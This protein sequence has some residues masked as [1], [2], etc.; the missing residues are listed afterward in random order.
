MTKKRWLIPVLVMLVIIGAAGAAFFLS[1][2]EGDMIYASVNIQPQEQESAE[3]LAPESTFAITLDYSVSQEQLRAMLSIEPDMGEYMIEGSG[4]KWT[5]RPM[6]PL[7]ENT[8]YTVR[9]INPDTGAAVQSF[10]FQTRS[11]LLVNTV[12]PGDGETFVPLE[13]GIE[14]TLNAQNV[15]LQNHMEIKPAVAGSFETN[16]YTVVFKPA[17]PLTANSIYRVTLKAGLTAPGGMALKEDYTFSFETAQAEDAQRDYER[18]RLDSPY[19]ET[20]LPGDPLTVKLQSGGEV[21]GLPFN[22][23]IHRYGDISGYMKE[24]REYNA[25]YRERYGEKTDYVANTTGLEEVASYTGELFS[26]DSGWGELYAILP[27]DLGEGW[28]VVTISGEDA[29]GSDQFVQKLVQVCNLSVYSQSADG[30]TLFWLN[31]PATGGPVAKA[32][33]QLEDVDGEG[34]FPAVTMADGTARVMTGESEAVYVTVLRDGKSVYFAQAPLSQAVETPPL[35][36]QYYTALYT[37]REAYQP[38][39]TIHFWGVV[40]PRTG[41]SALPQN[42]WVSLSTSWP[43]AE[44]Y[45]VKAAVNQADGTF[46]GAIAVTGIAKN[47]YELSVNDGEQGVYTSKGLS[48]EKYTKPPYEIGVTLDK[49][50]YYFD[51]AVGVSITARYFDGTPVSGETLMLS[52]SY[53]EEQSVTLDAS[54][55]AGCTVRLKAPNDEN[56]PMGWSPRSLWIEARNISAQDVYVSGS[57]NATVL[58]SRIALKLEGDSLERLTIRTAQLDD[59]KLNGGN[60]ISPLE[61]YD[62]EY[63]RLAGAPVDVPVTVLIHSVTRRQVETGSYYD[64]VNKRTVTEYETE[65][66]EAVAETIETKT[67]G[68]VVTLEGLAYKNTDDTT[69]WAEARVDGGA[70]G[71]V[72]ETNQFGARPYKYRGDTPIYTFFNPDDGAAAAPVDVGDTVT[73]RLYRNGVKTENTGRVLYSILQRRSLKNGV[74]DGETQTLT[75]EE[76]FLPNIVIAGAYFDGRHIYAVEE[77]A[78]HYDYTD[79]GLTVTAETDKESYRPGET[80]TVTLKLTDA[81]GN[82]V[83]G[84]VCVGVADEAAFDVAEQHAELLYQLYSAVYY[85]RLRR[86]LSY[87]EYD[88][89]ADEKTSANAEGGATPMMADTGGGAGGV[90]LREDFADTALFKTAK[91]DEN[92]QAS[93]TFELP[94]NVTSW[95]ITALAVTDDLK[96][97]DTA[98]LAAAT[99][100]FYLTPLYTDTYLEGDDVVIAAGAVGTGANPGDAVSYTVTIADAAGKELDKQTAE[101]TIGVRVPFSFGKLEAGAYTL[102]MESVCGE[103]SDAVRYPFS[104]VKQALTTP[105][106]ENMPLKDTVN[107]DSVRYPVKLMVYDQRMQPYMEGLQ[108]LSMQAGERTEII[109]AAYRAQLAYNELL[110]EAEREPVR[111]DVRLDDIQIGDGG[112]R[113]L[114]VSESSAAVTAK[115]LVAAPELINK[116][117]ARDYLKGVL[118]NP[119]AAQDDRVM[120]Y[121]GLAAAK[122]PILLDLLRIISE[123]GASMTDAQRLYLGTGLALLGDFTSADLVYHSLGGRLVKDGDMLYAEGADGTLDA[124]IQTSAAALMLASVTSNPDADALM[125]Y[126]NNLD[127][128]RAKSYSTLANLE[129][130][131]YINSFTPPQKGAESFSY[132][133]TQGEMQKRTLENGGIEPLSMSYEALKAANFQANGN[134]YACA[135]YTGYADAAQIPDDERVQ[136]TKTYTPV[137]GDGIGVS[138]RVRVDLTVRFSDSAPDGCYIVSDYIPSGMRYMETSGVLGIN[139]YF[140]WMWGG[141]DNE[142]QAVSGRI[143]RNIAVWREAQAALT[144]QQSGERAA[145]LA[146]SV[147]PLPDSAAAEERGTPSAGGAQVQK[148]TDVYTLTYYVSAALP[149]EFVSESAYVTPY[150]EGTAAKSERGMVTVEAQG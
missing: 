143:Y 5:L 95:R 85:P 74:F 96:A 148:D 116:G 92:G 137:A 145:P 10:A 79:K 109:A 122:E 104:V 9:V 108:Y 32:A 17:E 94:D 23:K 72:C 64:Y 127:R 117:A 118:Q 35:S 3:P 30:D 33:L 120:A 84:S 128:D 58:P 147:A 102:T 56:D 98:R 26:K 41:D 31:D 52:G 88:T 66:D 70:A 27:D 22:V 139:P 129:M 112:V 51:E 40:K 13:T 86:S 105:V 60:P 138:D 111:R 107:I 44:V 126:M 29:S 19:A 28:Y 14:I 81:A 16:G 8:V 99:L 100:P 39:D 55:H 134:V 12:Y 121:L 37:D 146:D 119:A 114:P 46:E 25:F 42:V 4:K 133:D 110:D 136:I 90:L 141:I 7:E 91:A 48:L 77:Y 87:A 63:D 49:D 47:Y 113:L 82:P 65:L 101:G 130:L 50:R 97:G 45:R 78:V 54:G 34:E 62:S 61:V 53:I 144:G 59:T 80:A 132:T 20:F 36:E 103:N 21:S 11:D 140:D 150:I 57:A 43:R 93:M 68:G 73:L 142:G 135:L 149:G 15:D 131:C 115:M 18:L 124:R 83:P 76:S 1:R 67:S 125:R 6:N 2:P 106:Y 75:M 38:S 123:E 24:L 69:Y 71:T 89:G